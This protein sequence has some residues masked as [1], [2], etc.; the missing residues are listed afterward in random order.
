M[1]RCEAPWNHLASPAAPPV[2]AVLHKLHPIQMIQFS[3]ME[4]DLVSRLHHGEL[5][6][7]LK[8]IFLPLSPDQ[9]AASRW[10]TDFQKLCMVLKHSK[11]F[12]LK[13]VQNSKLFQE[14]FRLISFWLYPSPSYFQRNL[15]WH[16]SHDDF[17][18]LFIWLIWHVG[19]ETYISS[20]FQVSL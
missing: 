11:N 16:M 14:P 7:I 19:G 15:Q 10:D 8:N 12:K 17:T 5:H 13:N 1:C 2:Q 4:L 3:Q 9:L 18:T 20:N 6:H